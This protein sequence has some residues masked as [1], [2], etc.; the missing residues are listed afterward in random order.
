MLKQANRYTLHDDIMEQ[1]ITAIKENHWAPGSKLPAEQSL[2]AT[3]GVSRSCI[4]EVLKALA[5]SGVLEA[6]PGQGTFLSPSA[7]RILNGSQLAKAMFSEYTYTELIEIRRLLEGQA[8]FWA[9]SRATP[10]D[11]ARLEETLRGGEKGDTIDTIHEKFH[12]AVVELSGN[13]ILV[14]LLHSLRGEIL[15]QREFHKVVLPAE[16]RQQH[17]AIYEAIHER[18]PQKARRLMLKHVDFYWK[19][20]L[21]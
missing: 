12:S 18:D 16:D 4:R 21:R 6:R 1:M 9:A 3:F 10:E 2:A 17:W 20:K 11:L 5:H 14:K 13:R 19:K 15:T 7:D 8:A